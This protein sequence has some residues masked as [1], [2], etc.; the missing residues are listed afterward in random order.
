[1]K[2]HEALFLKSCSAIEDCPTDGLPEIAIA[3]RSNVGKS[4]L[5][6]Q[7]LKSKGLAKTSATPGKTRLINYFK[8]KLGPN[9]PL[10]FYFV[11]LP[12]YGYAKVSA[13]DRDEWSR[14][15][16][17]YLASRTTLCG[18]VVLL[19]IRRDPSPLDQQLLLWNEHYRIPCLLVATKSDQLPR[20][21]QKEVLRKIQEALP[22]SASGLDILPFS[23]KTAEGRE[24]LL[25]KIF[26][27][28]KDPDSLS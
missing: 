11:D 14:R 13:T 28:L 12:G 1:M 24:A 3:G 16:N 10:S 17:R 23:S 22:P 15:V 8:V 20:G 18:L 21:R 26:Q 4:S 19:D 25:R 27:I 9:P 2:I 6:N 7:L 5:L